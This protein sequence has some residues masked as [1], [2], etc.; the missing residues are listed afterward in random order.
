MAL[1]GVPPAGR[2]VKLVLKHSLLGASGLVRRAGVILGI[3]PVGKRDGWL[4]SSGILGAEAG[5]ARE[6]ML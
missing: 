3:G 1:L 2:A 6:A 5:G 4:C